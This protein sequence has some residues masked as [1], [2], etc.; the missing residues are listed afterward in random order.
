M[1]SRQMVRQS[2]FAAKITLTSSGALAQMA[3]MTKDVHGFLTKTANGASFRTIGPFVQSLKRRKRSNQNANESGR[4][5]FTT[6]AQRTRRSD[7][8]AC[9]RA[10]RAV[11]VQP[12]FE[13]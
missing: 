12:N 4:I 8:T 5:S 10:R 3:S 7:K 11:V 13:I 9:R 1:S 6:T 2:V